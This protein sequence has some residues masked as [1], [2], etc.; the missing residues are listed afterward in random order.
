ME[1][2][3]AMQRVALPWSQVKAYA[4]SSKRDRLGTGNDLF[5]V[6]L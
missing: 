5:A 4:G 6:P 1:Q 2:R 3:M